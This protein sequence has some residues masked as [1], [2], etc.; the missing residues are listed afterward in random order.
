LLV[1]GCWLLVRELICN[2]QASI[3]VNHFAMAGFDCIC[4]TGIL[5]VS[6]MGTQDTGKM[7]VAHEPHLISQAITAA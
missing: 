3:S 1:V 7:P 5:P 6:G 4:A 2:Q